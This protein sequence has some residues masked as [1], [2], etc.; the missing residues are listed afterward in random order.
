MAE[1]RYGGLVLRTEGR[2]AAAELSADEMRE[3]EANLWHV[4][5]EPLQLLSLARFLDSTMMFGADQ[6]LGVVLERIR[7]GRISVEFEASRTVDPNLGLEAVT[8]MRL[9]E[10]EP[11]ADEDFAVAI[12]LIGDDDKPIAN[13]RYR[14]ELPDGRVSEGRTGDDGQAFLWGLTKAGDCKLTFPD[15]DEEAWESVESS[16]L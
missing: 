12:E 8:L 3:V 1:F 6:V 16:P 4:A 9:A 7:D 10:A 2:T 13:A 14:L 5:D 11:M 15:L